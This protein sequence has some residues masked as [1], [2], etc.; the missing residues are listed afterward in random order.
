MKAYLLIFLF[1]LIPITSAEV[2]T[3][4]NFRQ[5]SCINLLQ[6]CGNCTY[7]NITTVRY[8]NSSVAL[9]SVQMT[10]IGAE[11]N[12]TFC[13]TPSFGEYIV[14]GF[15]DIDGSPTAWS[16]NLFVTPNGEEKQGDN[17]EIFF[18][19]LFGV[20]TFILL[21]TFVFNLAK[22]AT[23]SVKIMDI[24]WSWGIYFTMLFMWWLS[25]DYMTASFVRDNMDKFITITAFSH[26]VLPL[27]G[28]F[29]TFFIKSTEKKKPLSV[30]E[31]TGRVGGYYRY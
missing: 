15:G 2:Q 27:I 12:Y 24:A 11:Y 18:F 19:I 31:L 5:N 3:L 21:F 25:Q 10:K 6:I 22:T 17:F 9:S 23:A 13:S 4:G 30:P 16:Y 26:V 8:P 29:V 14:S 28:F 20:L 7:N 1:L